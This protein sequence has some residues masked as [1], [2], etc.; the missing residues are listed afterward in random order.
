MLYSLARVAHRGGFAE[1]RD[2]YLRQFAAVG[3]LTEGEQATL[4]AFQHI[5]TEVEPRYQDLALQWLEKALRDPGLAEGARI[6]ATYLMADL[7][8]RRGRSAEA[9]P[10]YAEVASHPDAAPLLREMASTLLPVVG[11]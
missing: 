7:L 9:R 6:R 11:G 1:E 4:E 2:D 3:P 8:R 10:L 5:A